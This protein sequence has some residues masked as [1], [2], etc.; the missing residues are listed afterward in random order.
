VRALVVAAGAVS[1][2]VASA[3]PGPAQTGNVSGEGSVRGTPA[4][5]GYGVGSALG[6]L[7]YVPFK[8]VFCILG[9]LGSLVT[10]P[11]STEAAGKVARASCGGTWVITPAVVRGE[12]PVQ[13]VGEPRR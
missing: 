10:F 9:G 6:T 13:F 7:V 8:G 5:V 12:E 2:V 3:L 11:F 4:E 1:L